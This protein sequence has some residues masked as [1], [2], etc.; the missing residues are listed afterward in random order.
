MFRFYFQFTFPKGSLSFKAF[1][2]RNNKLVCL[3]WTTLVLSAQSF[4]RWYIVSVQNKDVIDQTVSLFFEFAH[5]GEANKCIPELLEAIFFLLLTRKKQNLNGNLIRFKTKCFS[6]WS[7]KTG[8]VVVVA[9]WAPENLSNNVFVRL[10]QLKEWKYCSFCCYL[11]PRKALP[12]ELTLACEWTPS[13]RV[14]SKRVIE[15]LVIM[16]TRRS[17][18]T[19]HSVAR[20]RGVENLLFTYLCW[21]LTQSALLRCS[22]GYYFVSVNSVPCLIVRTKGLREFKQGLVSYTGE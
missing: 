13:M 22:D 11:L 16:V 19:F 8:R 1:F 10:S 7:R 2:E 18:S 12:K 9:I 6:H 14:N 15:Y 17:S 5:R 4:L 20:G 3:L 21:R